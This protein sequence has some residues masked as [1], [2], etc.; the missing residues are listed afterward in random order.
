MR[1]FES[2][3]LRI[4]IFLWSDCYS[5]TTTLDVIRLRTKKHH[6]PACN[7]K[8]SVISLAGAHHLSWHAF[9][10]RAINNRVPSSLKLFM[11]VR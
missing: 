11:L 10:T 6:K 4:Y 7:S 2:K 3:F 9:L 1:V 8:D 5:F